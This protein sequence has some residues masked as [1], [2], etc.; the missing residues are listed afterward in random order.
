ML[1]SLLAL[2]GFQADNIEQVREDIAGDLQAWATAGLGKP[3]APAEWKLQATAGGALERI[4]EFGLYASDPVVRRSA[5]L[6]RTA[7]AKSGRA[8]SMNAATASA[9][10]LAAGDRVRVSQGGAEA[11]LV[12]AIDAS[13]PDGA[14]RIARGMP[15][16]AAL[17]EGA[18]ALEKVAVEVAA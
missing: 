8:A 13:L 6:Q 4:A 15:E 9:A 10:R 18:I 7:A 2:P 3:S 11:R 12:V 14:V 5:P 1:G 16:T 17:G